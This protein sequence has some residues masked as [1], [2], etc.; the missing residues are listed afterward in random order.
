[1]V[2]LAIGLMVAA[3]LILIVALLVLAW[4]EIDRDP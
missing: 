2:T 4:T 3:A 1:M